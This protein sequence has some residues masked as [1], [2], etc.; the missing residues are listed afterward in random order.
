MSAQNSGTFT[1][2]SYDMRP[3]NAIDGGPTLLRYSA[4]DRF[5]GIIEGEGVMEASAV[6]HVDGSGSYLGLQRVVGR[7]GERVGSFVLQQQ[8]TFIGSQVSATWRVV[9]GS[10]TGDFAGISGSGG[11]EAAQDEPVTPY[12]FDFTLP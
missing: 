5:T 1:N 7:I 8:G 4:N 6:M 12:T 11:F 3:F 9:R 10:G 2:G